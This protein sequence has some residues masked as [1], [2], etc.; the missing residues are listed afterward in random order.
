M[1]H[2]SANDDERQD[3]EMQ[4]LPKRAS[5]Q[6]YHNGGL[7]NES[8][9]PTECT[10]LLGGGSSSSGGGPSGAGG[11]SMSR[12]YHQTTSYADVDSAVNFS[13][14]SQSNVRPES[15]NPIEQIENLISSRKC[16]HFLLLVHYCDTC[17]S[18]SVSCNEMSTVCTMSP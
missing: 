6:R 4:V 3:V 9:S 14:N 18:L 12:Y 7:R 16:T 8:V 1:A 5:Y 17:A 13:F 11:S 15:D 10:S 2:N